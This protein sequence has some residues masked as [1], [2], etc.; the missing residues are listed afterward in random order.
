MRH[1]NYNLHIQSAAAVS[2]PLE[3]TCVSQL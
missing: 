2:E 3:S 1:F